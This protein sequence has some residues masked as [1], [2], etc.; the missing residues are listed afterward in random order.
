MSQSPTTEF[1]FTRP[2]KEQ[3][4]SALAWQAQAPE[5]R[6][7]LIVGSAIPQGFRDGEPFAVGIANRRTW[8]LLP[9]RAR[10]TS[11][12]ESQR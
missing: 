5:D 7:L 1:G 10:D 11:T 8:W 6:W 3:L 12:Q 4:E 9:A 2:E